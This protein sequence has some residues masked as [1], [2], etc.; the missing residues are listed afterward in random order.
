MT[1]EQARARIVDRFCHALDWLHKTRSAGH[2]Q[3]FLEA[4]AYDLSTML[5]SRLCSACTKPVCSKCRL[6]D[7]VNDLVKLTGIST[8]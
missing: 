2:E 8:Q 6:H 4:I 5:Q 7:I 3:M 1:T